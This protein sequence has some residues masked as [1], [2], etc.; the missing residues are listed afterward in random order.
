MVNVKAGIAIA[1][2][3]AIAYVALKSSSGTTFNSSPSFDASVFTNDAK[4]ETAKARSSILDNAKR[5]IELELQKARLYLKNAT[6]PKPKPVFVKGIS[7]TVAPLGRSAA[8][9]FAGKRS[10]EFLSPLAKQQVR[11]AQLKTQQKINQEKSLSFVRDFITRNE[12][13]LTL[14]DNQYGL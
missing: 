5:P 4:S 14:L 8:D 13:K 1:V 3:G 12:Q 11:T 6:T 2:L 7:P 9:F 10:F